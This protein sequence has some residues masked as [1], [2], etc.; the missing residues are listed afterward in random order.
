MTHPSTILIDNPSLE[1]VEVV[2]DPELTAKEQLKRDFSTVLKECDKRVES[3]KKMRRE[4]DEAARRDSQERQE[5][6]RR[7]EKERQR[8]EET[9]RRRESRLEAQKAVDSSKAGL[10]AKCK[11]RK[12][13]DYLKSDRDKSEQ[14]KDGRK[15]NPELVSRMDESRVDGHGERRDRDK[16]KQRKVERSERSEGILRNEKGGRSD[17]SKSKDNLDDHNEKHKVRDVSKKPKG[18]DRRTD[19]ADHSRRSKSKER[20]ESDRH[21]KKAEQEQ[22]QG[23]METHPSDQRSGRHV[24][25]K[26]VSDK[27]EAKGGVGLQ[28]NG[29]STNMKKRDGEYHTEG[30]AC[31]DDSEVILEAG[32][33]FDMA[34]LSAAKP[35]NLLTTFS[36][37]SDT[38]EAWK[39]VPSSQKKVTWQEDREDIATK[40]SEDDRANKSSKKTFRGGSIFHPKY[41]SSRLSAKAAAKI[42]S[43][44]DR[45]AKSKKEKRT[46]GENKIRR[47]FDTK[48][49]T[50]S[51]SGRNTT[52][53]AT[54]S[55]VSL[56]DGK[57]KSSR[58]K[59]DSGGKEFKRHVHADDGGKSRSKPSASSKTGKTSMKRSRQSPGISSGEQR[60]HKRRRNGATAVNAKSF[61]SKS[62]AA[63]SFGEDVAFSF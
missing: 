2:H 36:E 24:R 41:T 38:P 13:E 35:R 17:R 45:E 21:R 1:I 29:S 32:Q 7:M 9:R 12:E 46:F 19:K 10:S 15:D 25:E 4:L 61:S 62:A 39:S 27:N 58:S 37:S 40:E 31:R 42:S 18:R 56:G 30:K 3:A 11:S 43:Q 63:Q 28:S 16:S 54:T 33:E 51:S 48:K 22:V 26:G 59:T 8:K 60:A 44:T 20:N 49:S 55:L 57:K 5:M 6:Q 50:H 14:R 47:H 52:S 23:K 34:A 53:S